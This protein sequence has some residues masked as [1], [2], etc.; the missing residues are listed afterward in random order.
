MK[1]FVFSVCLLQQSPI[2][3]PLLLLHPQTVVSRYRIYAGNTQYTMYG[4]EIMV[5]LKI[6]LRDA[7]S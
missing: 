6:V 1:L 5:H 3:V 2:R 4:R 7:I